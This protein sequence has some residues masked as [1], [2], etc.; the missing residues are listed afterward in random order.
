MAQ[1]DTLVAWGP[2]SYEPPVLDFATIDNRNGHP[3]LDF[4]STPNESGIFSAVMPN[5]YGGNGV[6][7]RIHYAMSIATTGNIDW[8]VAFELIGDQDQDIDNDGFAPINSTDNTD[9][10][11]TAGLVDIVEV[12]FTDGADMDSITSGNGFRIKVIRDGVSDTASG[13]AELRFLELIEI[14]A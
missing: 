7:V 14:P 8:D 4:A 13:D 10:P 5:H 6:R 11:T 1:G 3:V 9:V 2:L 12:D